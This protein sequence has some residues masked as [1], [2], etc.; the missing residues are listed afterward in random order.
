MFCF[1]RK[2]SATT[3]TRIGYAF[4]LT[5]FHLAIVT[6]CGTVGVAI[7]IAASRCRRGIVVIFQWL[8]AYARC[9]GQ[10]FRESTA[11][12]LRVTGKAIRRSAIVAAAV[13][14]RWG[15]WA[16]EMGTLWSVAHDVH[17]ANTLHTG[18]I[19]AGAVD[20][21]IVVV[22]VVVVHDAIFM[23]VGIVVDLRARLWMGY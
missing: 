13:G 17:V 7:V 12:A 3:G 10:R 6:S 19:I 14:T 11:V 8:Y 20:A 18:T 5:H 4:S 23:V 2:E 21:I 22:V 16:W 1:G 9:P 15:R